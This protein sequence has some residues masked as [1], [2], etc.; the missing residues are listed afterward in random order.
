MR[1]KYSHYLLPSKLVTTR[2]SFAMS[3]FATPM[4]ISP[5]DKTPTVALDGVILKLVEQILLK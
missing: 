4:P 2:Y 1:K 3:N 5:I